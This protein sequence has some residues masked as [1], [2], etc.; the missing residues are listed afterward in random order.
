M[1]DTTTTPEGNRTKLTPGPEDH[2]PNHDHHTWGM[3]A[4]LAV[5]LGGYGDVELTDPYTGNRFWFQPARDADGNL[6]EFDF[7]AVLV[8]AIQAASAAGFFPTE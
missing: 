8:Q 5:E 1:S 6:P 4:G 2:R 7:P 3:F